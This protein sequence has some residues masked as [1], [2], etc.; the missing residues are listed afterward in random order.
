MN[1]PDPRTRL[2]DLAQERQVS[3]AQISALIGRNSSYLQQYVRK[4]S[5]RKL[6]ENDRRTLA[7][8]FGV[9]E[10]ELGAPEENYPAT[11]AKTVRGDWADIPRLAVGASAGP[12]ALS[13]GEQAIGALRFSAR[14]LRQQRLDPA[15][16]SAIAV[17]GDSMEPV[18]RDGDEILVDRTPRPL[19]DGIHVVRVDDAVLVKR[20][21]SS[22]PAR[23]LLLSDNAA[24]RPLE[25]PPGKLELIGRVVWKG[26]RL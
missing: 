9:D 15:M 3:L 16:L 11:S 22:N 8:F 18:L 19:R 13:E 25:V 4:G 2:L 17:A 21:D 26:G 1:A 14:W 23:L 20:I 10:S 5:P 7:R 24:Y 12:G 6:E